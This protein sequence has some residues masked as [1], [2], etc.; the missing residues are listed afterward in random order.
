MRLCAWVGLVVLLIHFVLHMRLGHHYSMAGDKLRCAFLANH[1]ILVKRLDVETLLPDCI[2]RG[3]LTLDEQE[4]VLHEVTS[5]QKT[6]RFLTI[7]HRRGRQNADIF[8]ELLKILSDEDVTPGQ[9]L[10]DVLAQIRADSADANIQARFSACDNE[11]R[12]GDQRL[13]LQR[14][15]EKI[16]ET[17]AVNEILPQ[18]ISRGVVSMQE[19]EIIRS[20]LFLSVLAGQK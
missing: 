14:I 15:E 20:V 4:V 9:L 16:V 5:S 10:D 18:L 19:N 12:C 17:L 2:S 11:Q 1:H 8:D 13:S 3:L 6:D 7:I